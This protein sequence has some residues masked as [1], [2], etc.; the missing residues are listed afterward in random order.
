ML[1]SELPTERRPPRNPMPV[2]AD[3][4]RKIAL[5]AGDERGDPHV[6]EI[7]W[8]KLEAF[9]RSHPHLFVIETPED[10]AAPWSDVADVEEKPAAPT[11]GP[12]NKLK[13][14]FMDHMSWSD[15]AKG[16]PSIE[17]TRKGVAYKVVL[18]EY[19]RSPEVG[20]LIIDEDTGEQTFSPVRFKT[21][22]EARAGS[23]EALCAL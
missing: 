6:R 13:A 9:R 3:L 19:K 11:K 16:N 14:R 5:V 2:D 21:Y 20:F 10:S 4:I 15:T 7:A 23:W 8:S 18:F 22:V 12:V 17:V 1:W